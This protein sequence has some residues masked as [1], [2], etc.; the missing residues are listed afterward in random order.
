VHKLYALDRADVNDQED[1]VHYIPAEVLRAQES[2]SVPHG[3]LKVKLGCPLIL[4]RNLNVQRGLCNSTC[5]TLTGIRRQV[6]HVWLPNGSYELLPRINFT[7]EEQGVP[8]VLQ[9]RQFPVKLAF[10]LTINKS[11][12]QSLDEVGVDLRRPVFT[13]G[14]LYVALSRA[15]SV[16]GVKI[17]I[18]SQVARKTANIVF[19]EVLL[20]PDEE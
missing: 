9:R 2:G 17:L 18:D 5:F 14:Q 3:E 6:L 16:Q 4:L 20:E 19:P 13:H 8:W 11:Q 15:I 10:A 1:G 12:G 7:V